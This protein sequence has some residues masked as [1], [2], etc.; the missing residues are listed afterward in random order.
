MDSH[1][2]T[3]KSY[4]S[5]GGRYSWLWIGRVFVPSRKE[6]RR[7]TG[8]GVLS[9]SGPTVSYE[10]AVLR[11]SAL[12]QHQRALPPVRPFKKALRTDT[13]FTFTFPSVPDTQL[14]ASLVRN[15]SSTPPS[16]TPRGP[17]FCVSHRAQRP[18]GRALPTVVHPETDARL[19]SEGQLVLLPCSAQP[20]DSRADPAARRPAGPGRRLC[21]SPQHPI[22]TVPAPAGQARPRPPPCRQRSS[23]RGLL[24][25]PTGTQSHSSTPA[26]RA[27]PPLHTVLVSWPTAAPRLH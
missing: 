1:F 10:L 13:Q 7:K 17:G 14:T 3:I 9:C 16:S 5:G 19:L 15:S 25:L 26:P 23:P 8:A 12:C 22:L 24:F 18:P 4:F 20:M 11:L 2:I 6:R 21:A 27:G